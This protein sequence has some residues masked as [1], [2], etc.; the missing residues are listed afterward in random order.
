MADKL[1]KFNIKGTL[2]D[3]IDAEA[4]A[5]IAE[6]TESVEGMADDITT[7]Q[8]AAEAAQETANQA[9]N[10]LD[11][12]QNTI[13][14]FNYTGNIDD[15]NIISIAWCAVANV[16]GTLPFSTGYFI[17]ETMNGTGF[18]TYLQKA[19]K[20]DLNGIPSIA[21]RMFANNRWYPWKSIALS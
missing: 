13:T 8:S 19:Y 1:S 10:G 14:S 18:N 3:V 15:L 21:Y 9:V 5:S 16:S 20:Y 17:I 2:A 11:T 12:K 6:L 4:R 7:A